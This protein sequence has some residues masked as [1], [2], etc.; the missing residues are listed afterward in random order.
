VFEKIQALEERELKPSHDRVQRTH[1]SAQA[2]AAYDA[3]E[4][5]DLEAAESIEVTVCGRIRRVNLKGSCR[6]C[7]S[8]MN[9]VASSFFYVSMIWMSSLQPRQR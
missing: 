8:K 6:S 9:M 3:L 4:P 1:T 5:S 7:I 2:I